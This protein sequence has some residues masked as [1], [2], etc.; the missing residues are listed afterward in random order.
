MAEQVHKNKVFV[1]IWERNDNTTACAWDLLNHYYSDDLSSEEDKNIAES[2]LNIRKWAG[3]P[4]DNGSPLEFELEDVSY[5]EARTTIVKILKFLE[6]K[7]VGYSYDDEEDWRE[8][9]SENPDDDE[10]HSTQFELETPGNLGCTSSFVEC[11]CKDNYERTYDEYYYC[12]GE[13]YSPESIKDKSKSDSYGQNNLDKLSDNIYEYYRMS[14]EDAKKK[15]EGLK[16][17]SL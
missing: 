13:V 11:K 15:I 9:Y 16:K 10:E 2:I 17:I 4:F 3:E 6:T 5:E 1:Q 12:D 8:Y 14:E 7:L